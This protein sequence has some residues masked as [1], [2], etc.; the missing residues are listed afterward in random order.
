MEATYFYTD[1][2][3][4]L[5]SPKQRS[6]ES[7]GERVSTHLCDEGVAR[8]VACVYGRHCGLGHVQASVCRP[9]GTAYR[10]ACRGYGRAIALQTLHETL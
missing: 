4:L 1:C 10:V 5:S 2:E 9:G 7:E 6:I 8:Y 3:T